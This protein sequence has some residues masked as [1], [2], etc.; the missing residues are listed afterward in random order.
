MFVTS[1]LVIPICSLNFYVASSEI[2]EVNDRFVFLAVFTT[3]TGKGPCSLF[4]I[5][6]FC[7]P[8]VLCVHDEGER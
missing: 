5:D 1:F 4:Q 8:L 6:F 3:A 2:K 7:V